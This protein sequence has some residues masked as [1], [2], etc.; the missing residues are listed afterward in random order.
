MASLTEAS[1]LSR[2]AIRYSIY[3]IILIVIARFTFNAGVTIYKRIFPPP[4]PEPTV[5]FGKLPKLPFPIKPVPEDLNF[6]LETAE[7]K[8]PELTTQAEIYL[9]PPIQPN[10]KALDDAK[11]KADAL[12][13]SAN[14]KPIVEGVPNVYIFPK[15]NN[16][17]SNLTINIIT[18]VFSINYDLTQDRILAEGVPPAP[19]PAANQIRSLLS[20]ADLLPSDLAEGRTTH[21]FFKAEGNKFIPVV[22]LSESNLIQI[23]FFRKNYGPDEGFPSVT[24]NYP[25]ANVWF[26]I[27]N[28]G[29][30]KLVAGE[31]NYFPVDS[32]NS[33]TYPLRTSDQAWEDLKNGKGYIANLGDNASGNITV[34]RVYLAYYDAGQYTEFF[35]PVVVFE[36]DNNFIAYAPAVTEEYYGSEDSQEENSN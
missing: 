14:G 29:T 34:R 30:K 36:G 23:H 35:Q 19:E 7:G 16:I 20:G 4:P 28:V 22:S 2:K 27:G 11:I 31:Y 9:M 25:V 18:G 3:A 15:R 17:P 8:L 24:P 1:I 12:E 33:G 6:D 10:I 26:T 32:S 21:N 13:F 5:T